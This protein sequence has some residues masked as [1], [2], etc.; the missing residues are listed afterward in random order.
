M[1]YPWRLWLIL[2]VISGC[3]Y[4]AKPYEMIDRHGPLVVLLAM[5]AHSTLHGSMVRVPDDLSAAG[6]SL[7][8]LDLPCHGADDTGLPPLQCWRQRIERGDMDIFG[9]FC[10]QLSAA[11]T[12]VGSK[13]VAVVGQSRGAYVAVTC[14][15]MDS[16][17]TR[18]ALL[19]PVTDLR[20]LEEF[21]GYNG[22][23][24]ELPPIKVPVYVRIGAHDERVGTDSAIA[25][26]HRIGAHIDVLDTSGHDPH[27]D[28]STTRWLLDVRH[29]S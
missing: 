8:S 1:I 19:I 24:P 14:A 7:M 17:I 3:T 21:K 20:R 15:A 5:S 6:F 18:L 13:N 12:A 26:A 4:S 25:Y 23:V 10:R 9:R 27:E 2:A 11:I 16:R 22:P 29:R 28:G